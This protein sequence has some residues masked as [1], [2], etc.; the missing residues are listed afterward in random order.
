MQTDQRLEQSDN[1]GTSVREIQ[2]LLEKAED[3]PELEE[4]R[5]DVQI[6]IDAEHASWERKRAMLLGWV[7]ELERRMI[8]AGIFN[9]PRTAQMRSW[10]KDC[11]EPDLD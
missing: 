9:G 2:E 5:A 3:V 8:D 7:D 4:L 10:Y 1:A 11:G 6:W